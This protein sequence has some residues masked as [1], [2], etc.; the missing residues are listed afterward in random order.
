MS[1]LEKQHR[2]RVA[3]AFALVYVLWGGT[4]LAMRVAVE[5]IPPYV[6]GSVRFL[7]AGASMLAWCALSGRK[8]KINRHDLPRLLTVGVLLL[9]VANMGVVW[10]EEYVSSGLTALIVAAV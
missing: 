1:L 10:A 4:Y 8:I 2:F 7:I 6:L 9:S 3:L 5:H